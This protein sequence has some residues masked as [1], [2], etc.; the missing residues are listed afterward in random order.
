MNFIPSLASSSEIS[1]V[2][3]LIPGIDSWYKDIG[4]WGFTLMKSAPVSFL[5]VV[6]TLI[7]LTLV[8]FLISRTF[9][10]FKPTPDAKLT[11]RTFFE[12]ILDAIMNLLIEQLGSKEKA[13]KYLPLIAALAIFILFNNVFALI[14]GFGPPT[15]N[16]N[17][18]VGMALIV[19][20]VSNIAGI[21]EHGFFNYMAQ[22]FGPVRKWYA[23]PLMILM[24][25]IEIIGQL[26]R[27]LSLSIRLMGNM[28][29]DHAT[30]AVLATLFA[31]ALPAVMMFLGV[32]VV[33][34]QTIVFCILSVVYISMAVSHH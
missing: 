18:N 8:F 2:V 6:T 3:E 31:I 13:K 10:K 1:G 27:P 7:S 24:F 26:A 4:A 16:L 17:T 5:H 34:I 9:H 20:F 28:F 30:V 29:G 21:R 14:P 15:D 12:L 22:F 32:V 11:A 19:F 25:P 23:L 33:L